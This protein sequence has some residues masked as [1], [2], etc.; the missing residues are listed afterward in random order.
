MEHFDVRYNPVDHKNLWVPLWLLLFLALK[1][2]IKCLEK[3]CRG[4]PHLHLSSKYILD[5]AKSP[6]QSS[7]PPFFTFFPL[8]DDILG[9][10]FIFVS[11]FYRNLN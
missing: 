9:L 4:L 1:M 5:H 11:D 8:Q 7:I 10:F 3:F 6:Q 2:N